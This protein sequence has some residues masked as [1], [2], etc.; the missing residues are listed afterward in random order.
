MRT[1]LTI[2]AGTL[3]PALLSSQPAPR[4]VV[5]GNVRGA[6]DARLA[7]AIVEMRAAGSASAARQATTD[8]DG[9]FRFGDVAPGQ[10]ELRVRRVGFRPETLQ[11]EVP[12]VDGGA[13][14]VPL[15][16][17]AQAM[18]GV[19]V[20]A[21]SRAT[22]SITPF[23]AFE[24][25]RAAGL[26]R[27]VTRADIDKRR[28]QRTSDLFRSVPGVVLVQGEAGTLVP[29]FRNSMSAGTASRGA[30]SQGACTPFYWMD[31]TP[32]GALA[33]DLDAIPP[34][35]IEGIELYS[36]IAT[37]PA[38]LRG[39]VSNA[40]CGVIAVW[41][42]RGGPRTGPGSVS[43]LQLAKLVES[44]DVFTADQVDDAAVMLPVVPFTPEYPDALRKT[45]GKVVAEFVVDANGDIEGETIGFVSS[46]APAF[47][48]S[49]RAAL[50]GLHFTAA[51]RKGHAVR[52]VVQWPVKFEPDDKGAA[53][54][55]TP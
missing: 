18:A 55:K 10:V 43:S 48:E 34:G 49:V 52:Q 53:V 42:R 40:V 4:Y 37:V 7:G 17:A 25:R 23:A 54:V 27:F 24:R 30:S 19:V 50:F 36:G 28:P 39:G 5:A 45:A 47:S 15:E 8:A 46:T 38:A 14:I 13:V 11:V 44:G 20:R 6:D 35:A 29:Q 9:A 31:G 22:A 51:Q 41:T 32:L 33:L 3:A 12:Q 16:R 1:R 26:G 21:Q 2:L